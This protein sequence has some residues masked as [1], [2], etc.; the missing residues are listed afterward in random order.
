MK[1]NS[2]IILF[3]AIAISISCAIYY[4]KSNQV[5]YVMDDIYMEEDTIPKGTLYIKDPNLMIDYPREKTSYPRDGYVPNEETAAK[6]AESVWL[7]IYG[8]KIY[9]QKPYHVKLFKDSIWV[10]NGNVPS[11]TFGENA[12]IEIRKKD[13]KILTVY[14][15]C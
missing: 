4:W 5:E 12:H 8:N 7:S 9:D 13:G 15:G 3:I 10:V 6:I 14:M 2:I 1:R 11:G